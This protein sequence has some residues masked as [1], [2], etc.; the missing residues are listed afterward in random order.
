MN[1][2]LHFIALR[3]PGYLLNLSYYQHVHSRAE[4]EYSSKA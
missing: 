3:Y 1:D 2:I 4:P